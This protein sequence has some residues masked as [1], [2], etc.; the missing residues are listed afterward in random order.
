MEKQR[1]LFRDQL[2]LFVEILTSFFITSEISTSAFLKKQETEEIKKQ[3]S[4]QSELPFSLN[5]VE[6]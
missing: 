6:C 5:A 3:E 1:D 2:L 4:L